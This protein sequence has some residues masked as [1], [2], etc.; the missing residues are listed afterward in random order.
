MRCRLQGDVEAMLNLVPSP[1]KW[2]NLGDG[3]SLPGEEEARQ[4]TPWAADE[5]EPAEPWSLWG[6]ARLQRRLEDDG[7]PPL[8]GQ[9]PAHACN[10]SIRWW[11][12]M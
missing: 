11:V 3:R 2:E 12:D 10:V 9:Q 8:E 6:V 1:D 7:I 4:Q 5:D